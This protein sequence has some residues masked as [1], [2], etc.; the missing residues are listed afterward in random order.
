MVQYAPYIIEKMNTDPTS[1]SRFL[2][3]NQMSSLHGRCA[4]FS[5]DADGYV[6]SEGAMA[7]IVKSKR[8]ALRDGD[9]IL[10]VI[11]STSV[12]HNGRSQGLVAPNSKAQ[13]SLQRSVLSAAGLNPAD[14]E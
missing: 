13:V 8:A 6:P 14:I 11:K 12:Q 10:G 3:A 9:N 5:K 1:Y 4:T 7:F 2:S